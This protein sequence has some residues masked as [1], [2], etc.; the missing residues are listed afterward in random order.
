VQAKE[1]FKPRDVEEL[2]DYYYHRPL[3]ALLVRL[4]APTSITP[5]QLTVAALA[6]GLC[7]GFAF[8]AGV[9]GQIFVFAG[10]LLLF[11]SIIFDCADGQLARVRGTSSMVGRA[12]DGVAD[13]FPTISAFHGLAFFID[14]ATTAP[15]W[16]IYGLG[17]TAGASMT[18]HCFLY[19]GV[20]NVYLMNTKPPVESR[21]M[22]WLDIPRIEEELEETR[23]RRNWIMWVVLWLF[24]QNTKAQ[25]KHIGGEQ[26]RGQAITATTEEREIYRDTFLLSMRLWSYL[27]LGTHLFLLVLSGVLAAFDYRGTFVLWAV[28]LVPMNVLTIWLLLTDRS[29]YRK[30]LARIEAHR[31]QGGGAHAERSGTAQAAL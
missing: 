7:S 30:A 5:N 18:W 2:I 16:L 8:Y 22:G 20:K 24:L 25:H 3:A 21:A 23:R 14:A 1:M 28:M 26:P 10:A 6:F 11:L 19:D 29:R 27:G 15:G 13:Y 4:V 9:S 12:L 31:S 17:Y